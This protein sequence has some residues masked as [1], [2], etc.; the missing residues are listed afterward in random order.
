VWNLQRNAENGW[1][2]GTG[3][4]EPKD[5]V[6]FAKHSETYSWPCD[7]AFGRKETR[8]RHDDDEQQTMANTNQKNY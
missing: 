5:N 7:S 8:A 4:R 3:G 2:A 1:S 6:H